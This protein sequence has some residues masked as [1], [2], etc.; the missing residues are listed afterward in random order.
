MALLSFR[1][2]ATGTA[3]LVEA[4]RLYAHEHKFSLSVRP[5]HG[6]LRVRAHGSFERLADFADYVA[7]LRGG[8]IHKVEAHDGQSE[9]G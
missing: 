2:P 4:L 9:Q 5:E 3:D 6:Y 8:H 7:P 1:L